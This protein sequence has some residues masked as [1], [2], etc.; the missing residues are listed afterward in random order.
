MG[1]IGVSVLIVCVCGLLA[2]VGL[3][4]AARVFAVT[5]DPR[6]EKVEAVLPGANCSG[7]GQASCFVLASQIVN[8]GAAPNLCVQLREEGVLEVGRILGREV[9]IRE[10]QVAVIRCYGGP[11]SKKLF[12]YGGFQ[13][14]RIAAY[15]SSGGNACEYN[16]MA[17]GDCFNICQFGAIT[18]TRGSTPSVD[19]AVC[20]GCGKCVKECP[21]QVIRLVPVSARTHVA[22]SSRDKGAVVRAIC[23]VGCIT[24]LKCVKIC[25]HQAIAHTDGL[26]EIDYAACTACGDCIRECPR[27]IIID[28]HPPHTGE[29]LPQ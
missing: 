16:C 4:I 25:P 7:C 1:V 20:T 10:R 19:A 21:K 23:P 12:V 28:L 15:Y 26:I 29:A 13:S 11:Q 8:S 14:C 18:H 17:L 6:I 2:G 24:C 22:C 3:A 9:S 27:N 5:V